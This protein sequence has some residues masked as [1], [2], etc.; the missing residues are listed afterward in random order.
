M[1]SKYASLCQHH[2]DMRFKT[3][4]TELNKQDLKVRFKVLIAVTVYPSITGCGDTRSGTNVL[5]PH[6]EEKMETG[7]SETLVNEYYTVR[8]NITE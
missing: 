5:P 8:C 6:S 7:F 2:T 1:F 4:Q 3:R